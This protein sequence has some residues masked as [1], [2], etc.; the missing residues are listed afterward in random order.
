MS[1]RQRIDSFRY[2]FQGM[3]DLFRTQPNSQFHLAAAVLVVGAGYWL[4][5]SR[6]E[7]VA[8]VLCIALVIALEALNT[9]LEYL[10]DLV[11]PDYHPLAGKA[12]DAGAA[13]VLIGA[14]GAAIVG[15]LIFGP[16]LLAR[17]G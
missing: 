11:S 12:K 6:I 7:W 3:A 10:T 1:L 14:I 13:A 17:L 8:I 5:L 2:A 16:K 4:Q 9:G 15:L